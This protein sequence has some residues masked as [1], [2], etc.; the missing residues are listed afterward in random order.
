MNFIAGVPIPFIKF[1]PRTMAYM[2]L[3]KRI[4][5]TSHS[6]LRQETVSINGLFMAI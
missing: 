5:V 6:V 2:M 1:H 3:N 4:F